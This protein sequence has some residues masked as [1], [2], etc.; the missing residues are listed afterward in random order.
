MKQRRPAVPAFL[1]ER[2]TLSVLPNPVDEL[3]GGEAGRFG[4]GEHPG[5]ERPQPAGALPR[6][7]G[8]R[9]LTRP[10]IRL[11]RKGGCGS[12]ERTLSGTAGHD[13]TAWRPPS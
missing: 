7:V 4:V 13:D 9:R 6:R 3:I 10:R 1:A 12:L 2:P 11:R 5:H 8:P